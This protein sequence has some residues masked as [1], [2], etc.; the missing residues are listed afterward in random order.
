[1]PECIEG[2]VAGYWI[3]A[4]AVRGPAAGAGYVGYAKVC[5]NEPE[6]CWA[7]HDW[8]LKEGTVATFGDAQDAVRAALAQA[9]N[10]IGNLPPIAAMRALGVARVPLRTVVP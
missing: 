8:L 5:C 10:T 2:P 9:R 6:D 7:P 1:M 4:Y 3:A